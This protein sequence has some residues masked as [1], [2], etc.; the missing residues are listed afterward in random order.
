Y[1]EKNNLPRLNHVSLPRMGA[2]H[3]I[4]EVLRSPNSEVTSTTSTGSITYAPL[5]YA[6]VARSG[7]GSYMP[8][9]S[10][11]FGQISFL[12]Q[13]F[14]CSG[15]KNLK[16]RQNPRRGVLQFSNAS[17]SRPPGLCLLSSSLRYGS[18]NE[19]CPVQISVARR[20][21]INHQMAVRPLGRER[22]NIG[23][24][25]QN[26]RNPRRGVLQFSAA[27]ASRPSGLCSLHHHPHVLHRFVVPSL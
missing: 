17:A 14:F 11:S 7:F 26:G 16:S 2:M 4:C 15:E 24:V 10:P 6:E 20:P 25:L 1:A 12:L 13:G 23:H 3:G 18:N 27:S 22:A 21:R 9:P 5:R 8:S 19:L